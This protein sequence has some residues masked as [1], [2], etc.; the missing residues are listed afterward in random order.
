MEKIR[1]GALGVGRRART[2]LS[3][4]SK[5]E[6]VEIV[7]I[8]DYYD[9][10]LELTKNR[11]LNM[12]D[13]PTYHSFEKM[14]DSCQMD[15][16]LI[17]TD[18]NKQ[19]EYACT[20]MERGIHVMTEVPAAYSI[21]DCWRLVDT[22]EKTGMI[23]QL[24]EQ[25]RYAHFLKEWRKLYN[26]GVLGKILY[27][28]GQYL[29]YEKWGYFVDKTSGDIFADTKTL[30]PAPNM[31]YTTEKMLSQREFITHWRYDTFKHPIYYL[32]HELSPILSVLNDRVTEVCC[33]GSEK[34]INA[35]DVEQ[36]HHPENRDIEVALMKT[37]KDAI[38]RMMVGFSTY[39]PA[40]HWYHIM[41][42]KGSVE[43][44]RSCFGSSGIDSPKLWTPETGWQNKPEWTLNDPD[45]DEKAK[46]S[47]HG[48]LDWYPIQNFVDSILNNAPVR[49]DVYR[50]VE[51]AAPAI[52]AAQSAEQG[53]VMLKI[54]DF[55][56]KYN[57]PIEKA[58]VI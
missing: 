16:L 52:L 32:P 31:E 4:Y 50:A 2:L 56:A 33:I 28:E 47:G 22:V 18:P 5:Y 23:Y 58:F 51:T 42:S 3:V 40:G 49:M 30:E 27:V 11:W 37:E 10:N 36:P 1:L 13:L 39:H 24:A 45:A 35:L 41:G 38:L 17:C 57:H 12:P 43:T 53:G 55:R 48:G 9:K 54:P 19:V 6:A 7:G 20:A 21:E 26:D 8:C 44:A 14:L 34:G 25:I 29:H 15:A 46:S